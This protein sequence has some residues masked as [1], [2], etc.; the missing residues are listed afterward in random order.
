MTFRETSKCLASHSTSLSFLVCKVGMMFVFMFIHSFNQY[1][2][3]T[4]EGLEMLSEP[5]RQAPVSLELTAGA[6][7]DD[8]QVRKERH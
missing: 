2:L 6:K 7:I 1:L 4:E 3:N 8:K 5:S